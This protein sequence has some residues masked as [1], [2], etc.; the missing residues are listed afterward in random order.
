MSQQSF[1]EQLQ[2]QNEQQ[3][4][5]QAL[6]HA[7]AATHKKLEQRKQNPEFVDKLRDLGI[8]TEEYPGLS[9]RLG[10]LQAGVH[11][12]GNRSEEY[13]REIKWL[14][15]N[16]GERMIAERE[17]GRLCKGRLREIATRVHERDD[18]DEK[19]VPD[20]LMMDERRAYRDAMEAVTN[21]KALAIGSTGLSSLTDATAVTKREEMS[22]EETSRREQ[23]SRAIG[24]RG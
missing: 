13:E 14:D 3:A 17:P 22:N 24:G 2:A 10:P 6:G 23:V 12:I 1:E 11:L 21:F 8:D 7:A 9:K 5:S 18:D 20:R 4:A 19:E 16:R 15:Q